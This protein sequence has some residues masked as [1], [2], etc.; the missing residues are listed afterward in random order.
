MAG[1]IERLILEK[2]ESIRGAD[3][4]VGILVSEAS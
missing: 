4:Q 1:E 2:L 3:P